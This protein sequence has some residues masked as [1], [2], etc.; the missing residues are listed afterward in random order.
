MKTKGP[1]AT[2]DIINPINLELNGR[3]L[4][5]QRP[6]MDRHSELMRECQRFLDQVRD[7]ECRNLIEAACCLRDIAENETGAS[8]HDFM[9]VVRA[10]KADGILR[11]TTKE[12]T[13]KSQAAV[14]GMVGRWFHSFENDRVKWQ[15][16]VL[17]QVSDENY[18]VQ[19]YDWLVGQP[20]IQVIVP[21]S[22]MREWWFYSTPEQMI[23]SYD[24]G[25]ANRKHD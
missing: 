10:W 17:A 4:P 12:R 11:M 22:Q 6:D 23:Y 15:G 13:I 1:A 20:S 16:N 14:V 5:T 7:A 19:L 8:Y 18:L 9:N 25:C 2:T 3:H 24:H 21:F